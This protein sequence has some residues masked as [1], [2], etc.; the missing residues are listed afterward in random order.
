M[1]ILSSRRTTDI[2][3]QLMREWGEFWRFP[4]PPRD[5]L[6][7][8]F[9][10]GMSVCLEDGTV[11]CLG[12]LYLTNSKACWLEF[13]FSNPEI[14]DKELRA[15]SIEFLIESLCSVARQLGYKWVFSSLKNESLK[16]RYLECGFVTGS[17][18]TTEVLKTL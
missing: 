14:K 3:Y 16:K 15:K 6:P 9:E 11:V 1:N 10:S 5:F 18:G 4:A 12:F 8:N 7:E 17:Q 13:V 2:D